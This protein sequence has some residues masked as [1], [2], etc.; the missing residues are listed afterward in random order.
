MPPV[1]MIVRTVSDD[2][3]ERRPIGISDSAVDLYRSVPS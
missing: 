2:L 3:V 1:F